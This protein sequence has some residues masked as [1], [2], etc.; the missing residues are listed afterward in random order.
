MSNL[1]GARARARTDAASSVDCARPVLL[2]LLGLLTL[3]LLTRPLRWCSGKIIHAERF[4]A[5]ARSKAS[6]RASRS[7]RAPELSFRGT[8][9]RS[10]VALSVAPKK[11]S[12]MISWSTFRF[13]KSPVHA[14]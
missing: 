6:F 13:G 3:L 4:H 2:L 12:F 8:R 7:A 9:A 11:R 14:M 1:S 10:T 5:H